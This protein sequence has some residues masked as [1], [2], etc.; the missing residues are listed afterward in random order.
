MPTKETLIAFRQGLK[1]LEAAHDYLALREILTKMVAL[2]TPQDE[3]MAKDAIARILR[4]KQSVEMQQAQGYP[5]AIQQLDQKYKDLYVSLKNARGRQPMPQ[6]VTPQPQIRPGVQQAKPPTAASQ[7]SKL[8]GLNGL[9]APLMLFDWIKTKKNSLMMGTALLTTVGGAYYFYN[10]LVKDDGKKSKSETDT[11]FDRTLKS[12]QKYHLFSKM[13]RNPDFA[14]EYIT[15]I[16]KKKKVSK[17]S[18]P[19]KLSEWDYEERALMKNMD[20]S[21]NALSSRPKFKYELPQLPEPKEISTDIVKGLTGSSVES[22][23]PQK[24]KKQR[25]GRKPKEESQPQVSTPTPPPSP[26]PSA[27]EPKP[28]KRRGR[29][30]KDASESVAD[31]KPKRQTRSKTKASKPTPGR[32]IP[33]VKRT[34]RISKIKA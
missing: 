28:K 10:K 21:F 15:G 13:T 27:E 8:S 30:K 14:E 1:A 18:S 31:S 22:E 29:P 11:S 4:R 9:T 12:I 26:A 3:P 17:K 7:L 5:Q 34:K 32:L 24:R 20:S 23:K 6:Q 2:V 16:T 19:D 25:R 33:I